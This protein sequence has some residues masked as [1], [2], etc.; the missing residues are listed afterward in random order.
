MFNS[1]QDLCVF[2]TIRS[3]VTYASIFR[4]EV[5]SEEVQLKKKI[6]NSSTESKSKFVSKKKVNINNIKE[7]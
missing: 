3:C 5:G 7:Y 1:L 4:T 2:Y 6:T